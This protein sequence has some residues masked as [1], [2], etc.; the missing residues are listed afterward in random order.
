MSR[1]LRI[2]L[3]CAVTTLVLAVPAA[4]LAYAT[5]TDVTAT[6]A[7]FMSKQQLLVSGTVWCSPDALGGTV[8]YTIRVAADQ[9]KGDRIHGNGGT[10]GTCAAEFTGWQ[11]W[12]ATVTNLMANFH[13]GS[14]TVTADAALC[15]PSDAAGCPDPNNPDTFSEPRTFDLKI[16]R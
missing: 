8:T 2:A 16:S 10:T 13:G 14:V 11:S 7:Q 9:G 15:G 3:I 12:S 4:V 6:T 5:D 1:A